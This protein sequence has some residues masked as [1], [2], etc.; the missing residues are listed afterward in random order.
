MNIEY[1]YKIGDSVWFM[2]DNKPEEKTAREIIEMCE[3]KESHLKGDYSDAKNFTL[4]SI[5]TSIKEKYN[6]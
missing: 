5:I 2:R 4:A 3:E 6:L 1:K